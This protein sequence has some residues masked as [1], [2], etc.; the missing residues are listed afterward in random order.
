MHITPTFLKQASSIFDKSEKNKLA[1]NAVTATKLD[2]IIINRNKLQSHNRLFSN[3]IDVFTKPT[4]QKRSGRCWLFALSN[5]MRIKMIQKYKLPPDFEFSNTYLFFY[6]K[7]EK[8]NYFLFLINKFKKEPINSRMNNILLKEPLSDGG[9]WNMILNLVNKYGMIPRNAYNENYNTENSY[10]LEDFISNKLRD[11]A[12][13]LRSILG[14]K[15]S[16]E[17]I[18]KCMNEIYRILVIFLGEPP[19]TF[20]WEYLSDGKFKIIPKLTPMHFY[21]KYVPINLNDLVLL[22]NNPTQNYFKNITIN[23]FNNMVDGEEIHYIN[24]PNDIIEC[25]IKKSLDHNDPL[26]FGCDV[27]KY[28]EKNNGILDID[29]LDYRSVFDTDI[30]LN[31]ANRLLYRISDVTHAMIFRGYDNKTNQNKCKHKKLTKKKQKRKQK[32]KGKNPKSK[33]RKQIGGSSLHCKNKISNKNITKYLVENSWGKGGADENLVMTKEYFDEYH[34]I[35]AVHKKYLPKSVIK[36][37]KQ[38][39]IRLELWDPFGYLLF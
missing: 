31:K 24:I 36:V 29:A 1:K 2:N 15:S 39:P 4:D 12:F 28:M 23:Y 8:C 17:F 11:Y 18:T 35:V 37:T 26:W 5:M 33:S 20:D 21:K 16:E 3:K 38:K 7:L 6:D 34:Y 25:V 27:G 14:D 19:V 32:S 13:G 22:A 9:N 10:F 30:Q